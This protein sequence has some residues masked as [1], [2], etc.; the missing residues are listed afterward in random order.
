[1]NGEDLREV[2]SQFRTAY[3]NSPKLTIGHDRLIRRFDQ[4]DGNKR[5]ENTNL[6]ISDESDDDEDDDDIQQCQESETMTFPV[7]FEFPKEKCASMLLKLLQDDTVRL[8][9]S[10]ILALADILF[11]KLI[12]LQ[13]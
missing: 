9:N 3:L 7:I 11:D 12:S 2:S 10:Q 13:M 8:E 4:I 6:P 1:M 5:V